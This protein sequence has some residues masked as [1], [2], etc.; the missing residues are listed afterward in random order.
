[1]EIWLNILLLL[2][3]FGLLIEGPSQFLE[4]TSSLAQKYKLSEVTLGLSLVAFTTSVP[5]LT[6]SIVAHLYGETDVV[7]A[8]II[9]SNNFNL[10]FIL[11]LTA[12]ISPIMINRNNIWRDIPYALIVTVM[13]FVLVNDAYFFGKEYADTLSFLEAGLIF[14]LF[15]VF[16]L[17]L[18]THEPEEN[19]LLVTEVKELPAL[20]IF[21]DIVVGMVTI[22]AG[23]YLT[24]T[25]SLEISQYIGKSTEFIA[26]FILA[27]GTSLPELVTSIMAVRKK[28]M[29]IVF[30]NVTGSNIFNI[31]FILP[32]TRLMGKMPYHYHL[33]TDL[34]VQIMAIV[35]VF[36]FSHTQRKKLLSRFEGGMLMLIF[37]VYMTFVYVRG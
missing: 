1:M 23:G 24:V 4:G 33:N 17:Y 3:G 27:T 16:L 31:V 30:S 19:E 21:E 26:I 11:G 35:L 10:L 28:R 18:V 15:I 14:L 20:L 5:E 34:I 8:N 7:F 32:V 12:L 29:D 9:G 2:L 13:L 37:I 6:V 36:L 22:T 25:Q